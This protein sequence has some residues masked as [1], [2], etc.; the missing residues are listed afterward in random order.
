MIKLN[1]LTILIVL[2][3]FPLGCIYNY[4]DIYVTKV[5]DGDTIKLVNG[6]KVRLIGIDSP[7]FH[8]SDKLYRDARRSGKSLTLIQTQGK[9]A[10][11]FTRDLVERR[12]VRLEFDIERR[13]KYGR[14][15][16]YVYIPVCFWDDEPACMLERIAGYEYVKLSGTNKDNGWYIFVNATIVKSGYADLMTI[17]PNLKYA[18]LLR[19]LY[20]EAKSNKRGLWQD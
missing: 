6:E 19:S 10:Y 11:E 8:E 20:F 1:M 13:D 18:D 9:R 7:E 16:A 15:L 4:D 14:L 12:Q 2:L 5:F 17:P 3:L